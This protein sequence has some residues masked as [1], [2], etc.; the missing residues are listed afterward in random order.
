MKI[1]LSFVLIFWTLTVEPMVC[2]LVISFTAPV[3]LVTVIFKKLPED[4]FLN[5]V[6][7][8]RSLEKESLKFMLRFGCFPERCYLKV[9]LYKYTPQNV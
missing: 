6:F 8:C 4:T 7:R 5:K 2:T 3:P 1:H 9:V